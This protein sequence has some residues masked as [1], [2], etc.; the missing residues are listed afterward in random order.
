MPFVIKRDDCTSKWSMEDI[1][2]KA[3]V[4][5]AYR[6][7]SC[8]RRMNR[9]MEIKYGEHFVLTSLDDNGL[10][11][12][13]VWWWITCQR[14]RDDDFY[15][16][17]ILRNL[18][19]EEISRNIRPI[20]AK[21]I[22]ATLTWLASDELEMKDG[23]VIHRIY[24]E[25]KRCTYDIGA[26]FLGVVE[27]RLALDLAPYE[28]EILQQ[29]T[30]LGIV[31]PVHW[32]A[33]SSEPLKAAKEDIGEKVNKWKYGTPSQLL[34]EKFPEGH[35]I[36]E[37]SLFYMLE[38]VISKVKLTP[39]EDYPCALEKIPSSLSK[40]VDNHY[41]FYTQKRKILHPADPRSRKTLKNYSS[42]L[43]TLPDPKPTI[44]WG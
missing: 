10:Y 43:V 13:Q 3:N 4:K 16:L 24:P 8:S 20:D 1:P 28:R 27:A 2:N 41:N 30:K 31:R 15:F 18:S 14:I 19:N 7:H 5:I 9:F 40:M 12:D 37:Y 32:T 39:G 6:C 23:Q 11:F 38:E 22:D 17:D 33:I 21:D 25:W 44:W 34:K 42:R 35:K 36:S 29:Y 26:L